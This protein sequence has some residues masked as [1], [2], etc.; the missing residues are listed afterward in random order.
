MRP[1]SFAVSEMEAERIG[2]I[3]DMCPLSQLGSLKSGRRTAATSLP[4]S[5][6]KKYGIQ[7]CTFRATWCGVSFDSYGKVYDPSRFVLVEL[8]LRIVITTEPPIQRM[9]VGKEHYRERFAPSS[10]TPCAV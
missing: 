7:R 5:F 3:K 9:N 6:C 2:S 4:D 10:I 8:P 1:V